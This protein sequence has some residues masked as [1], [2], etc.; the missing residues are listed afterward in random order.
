MLLFSTKKN[1]AKGR[2]Y[3]RHGK[4]AYLRKSMRKKRNC[5]FDVSG[6]KSLYICFKI[7]SKISAVT[8]VGLFLL[9]FLD[10]SL[11]EL[12]LNQTNLLYQVDILGTPVQPI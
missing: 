10:L 6:H 7:I 1:I 3:I 2:I 8:S 4:S 9:D 12:G 5:L 11:S